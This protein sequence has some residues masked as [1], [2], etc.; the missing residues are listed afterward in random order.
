M[1]TS[2]VATSSCIT[3]VSCPSSCRRSPLAP[4]VPPLTRRLPVLLGHLFSLF[5][6]PNNK[7]DQLG[8]DPAV[9]SGKVVPFKPLAKQPSVVLAQLKDYQMH[10]LSWLLNMHENGVNG[11]LGDEMG[12]GWCLRAIAA[13]IASHTS[14]PDARQDRADAQSSRPF[15]EPRYSRSSPHHCSA[16]RSR[17]L[18]PV[19][20]ESQTDIETVLTLALLIQ[21]D[22][23]VYAVPQGPAFP[24]R[25]ERA[26]KAEG[27]SSGAEGAV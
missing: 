21:R 11:I 3:T 25:R 26:T 18:D 10:G 8:Q 12:L 5:L 20:G 14:H 22:Q 19:G 7:I 4:V 16:Q 27:H 17:I 13:C 6:G 9:A 2:S 1:R 24:W 15:E 23:E